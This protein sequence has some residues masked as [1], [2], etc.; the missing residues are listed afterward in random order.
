M[1]ERRGAAWLT[2]AL[3]LAACGEPLAPVSVSAIDIEQTT[4]M[5]D[6]V[7]GVSALAVV[8]RDASGG[9]LP[10]PGTLVWTSANTAVATVDANGVV[11]AHAQGDTYI[12]V[13]YEAK[14]DSALVRVRAEV[15]FTA[16]V[17]A[18]QNR[19]LDEA[20]TAADAAMVVQRPMP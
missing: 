2:A 3:L 10:K 11:M 18:I 12:R 17:E 15:A 16:R 9:A 5:L 1:K 13:A 20:S 14:K 7:N 6:A 8:I 4:V 19:L